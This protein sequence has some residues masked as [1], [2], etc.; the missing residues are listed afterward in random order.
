LHAQAFAGAQTSPF[1]FGFEFDNSRTRASAPHTSATKRKGAGWMPAPL[2][3]LYI[4]AI[5]VSRKKCHGFQL[6]FLFAIRELRG[7]EGKRGLD[8]ISPELGN[9]R[10]LAGYDFSWASC[11]FTSAAWL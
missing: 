9:R 3:C 4:Q 11:F 6:Y 7:I 2:S 1:L 8:K 10:I 5:K